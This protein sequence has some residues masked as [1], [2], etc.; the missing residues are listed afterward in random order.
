MYFKIKRCL[1]CVIS[2]VG[3]I[4]LSPVFILLAAWVKLE[5][6]G[7]VFFRQKRYGKNKVPFDCLKFRTMYIDTPPNSATA[8]LK[9]AEY[10]ITRSGRLLRRIG[11]DELPQLFNVFKGDMSLIGPRPVVLSETKLIEERD[12]YGANKF[13]PGIGGWAQSNGRD[14][15]DYKTKA[16]L[17]GEYAQNFGFHMDV[18]CAWRTVIA[19]FTSDGF[20]EGHIGDTAYKRQV[21]ARTKQLALHK[22]VV[23]KVKKTASARK[24]A[25]VSAESNGKVAF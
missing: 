22:R 7:P 3:I 20:K 21:Q 5:S 12:K 25:K 4:V 9:N 8:D 1:D 24:M 6:E 18:S 19:I 13:L 11:L 17:D 2:L 14:E 15:L 10:Y 16:R 23:R